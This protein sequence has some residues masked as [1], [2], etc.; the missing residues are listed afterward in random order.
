MLKEIIFHELRRLWR[1][2]S[3]PVTATLIS[4]ACLFGAYNAH[5]SAIEQLASQ[6]AVIEEENISF[7]KMQAE[8]RAIETGEK[9]AP[10]YGSPLQAAAIN[11]FYSRTATLPPSSFA[12]LSIGQSDVYPSYYKV[13]GRH[14]ESFIGSI[15]IE[16]PV[17]LLTGR[18][19]LSFAIVFILPLFVIAFSYNLLAGERESGTLRLLLAQGA[20]MRWMLAGKIIARMLVLLTPLFAATG[21]AAIFFSSGS[22]EGWAKFL[23]FCAVAA[24]YAAF[25]FGLAFIVNL[26]GAGS[27]ANALS[28]VSLWIVLVILVPAFTHLA[29][30]AIYPVP[31]RLELIAASRD[32]QT[33]ARR[34]VQLLEEYYAKYP[35]R[36]PPGKD[37]NAYDFPLYYAAIQREI[38]RQIAPLVE[39]TDAAFDAQQQFV[40]TAAALSP[41]MGV[42]EIFNDLAGTGHARNKSFYGQVMQLYQRHVDF[43]EIKS[44][45]GKPL[46]AAEYDQMPR[47]AF[48]EE[49]LA[50]L[51][52]R[53]GRQFLLFMLLPMGI[54]IVAWASFCAT[55]TLSRLT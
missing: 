10:Q 12:F 11:L 23:I 6:Q 13:S 50:D 35:D 17:N 45:N 20:R 41:A 7:A 16:N 49:T 55:K 19:D 3:A 18:F 14:R 38:D 42:Q 8:G 27:A 5:R 1:D 28:L 39:R 24:T 22:A 21:L 9:P 37:L 30:T 32:A 43:F 47:F 54:G 46:E 53:V 44:F 2:R 4:L 33:A 51:I 15:E 40:G 48:V 52:A 25:W 26:S 34:P 29:A 31:S 36:R